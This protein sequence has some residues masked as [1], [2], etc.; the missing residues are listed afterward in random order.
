MDQLKKIVNQLKKKTYV[1]SILHFGSSLKKKDYH[2]I[3]LCL[4]TVKKVSLKQKLALQRGIPEKYDLCFYDDL[5]IPLK[6]EVLSKGKIVFTKNYYRLLRQIQYIDLEYPR[7]RAF[8]DLY[9][10][11]RVASL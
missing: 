4:M 9:H 8:L 11:A 5:P 1:E 6:K 2:D 7:F 10:A 3:D